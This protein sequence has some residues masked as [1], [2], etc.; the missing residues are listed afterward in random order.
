[1]K[2]Q[3]Q[4][5]SNFFNVPI[6]NVLIKLIYLRISS[7]KVIWDEFVRKMTI[8]IIYD[9]LNSKHYRPREWNKRVSKCY[10]NESEELKEEPQIE[11]SEKK[12]FDFFTGEKIKPEKSILKPIRE[13]TQ[14]GS[15]LYVIRSLSLR[16]KEANGNQKKLK[17]NSF[18]FSMDYRLRQPTLKDT[19]EYILRNTFSLNDFYLKSKFFKQ[20]YNNKHYLF[21]NND[22]K[23]VA[24]FKNKNCDKNFD[25]KSNMSFY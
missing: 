8:L 24:S 21:N 6:K 15:H 18:R 19:N 16:N 23:S 7:H 4:K 22:A 2:L 20:N 3:I 1:M 25:K 10:E 9:R 5:K 13:K 17:T 14:F 12:I 11:T